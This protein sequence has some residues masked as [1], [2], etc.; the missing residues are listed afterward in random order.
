MRVTRYDARVWILIALLSGCTRW[1]PYEVP[2]SPEPALPPYLRVSALPRESTVL[3][4]PFV[5]R[6]TIYGRSRGDTLG[7]A[8]PTIKRLERPR[9]DGV[10]TAATVV[11]GLA[12]WATVGVLAGVLE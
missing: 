4:E 11:G 9:L 10:R 7:I 1:E 2:T 3:F 12:A 6:D 5:R 8:L